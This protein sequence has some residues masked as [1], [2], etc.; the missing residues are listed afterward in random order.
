MAIT[1]VG[2]LAAV[3]MLVLV[4]GALGATDQMWFAVP[5][6]VGP[7]GCLV[8][9]LRRPVREWAGLRP[10]RRSAGGRRGAPASH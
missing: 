8:L 9:A 10:A 2:V 3:L 7:L 4:L 1:A 5:L 6:V